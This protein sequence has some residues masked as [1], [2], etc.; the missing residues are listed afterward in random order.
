MPGPPK[1][2]FGYASGILK[3]CS[4]ATINFGGFLDIPLIRKFLMWCADRWVIPYATIAVNLPLTSYI[5]FACK[6]YNVSLDQ[7]I[8]W[9]STVHVACQADTKWGN[10]W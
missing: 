1:P 5:T 9:H 3:S 10:V 2:G 8:S 6:C 7:A 4:K